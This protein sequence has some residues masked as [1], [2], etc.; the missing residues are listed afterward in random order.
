[1]AASPLL[2]HLLGHLADFSQSLV[3]FRNNIP[4]EHSLSVIIYVLC[5]WS[6]F[7][8]CRRPTST[9]AWVSCADRADSQR[10]DS[11]ALP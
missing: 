7:A 10:A 4:V 11:L 6:D 3:P 8:N 1:M 2:P 9:M 5:I